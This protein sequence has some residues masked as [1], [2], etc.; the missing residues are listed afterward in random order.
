MHFELLLFKGLVSCYKAAMCPLESGNLPA[1]RALPTRTLQLAV[2]KKIAVRD[3]V[4]SVPGKLNSDVFSRNCQTFV[5]YHRVSGD[6]LRDVMFLPGFLLLPAIP[7]NPALCLLLP[8]QPYL[9]HIR[10]FD[11]NKIFEDLYDTFV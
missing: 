10:S 6:S 11:L 7:H 5:F 2:G 3:G 4:M 1:Q 9:L 8:C